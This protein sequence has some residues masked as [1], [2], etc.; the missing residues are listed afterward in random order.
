MIWWKDRAERCNHFVKFSI[1]QVLLKNPFLAMLLFNEVERTRINDA[2]ASI[3][4][5]FAVRYVF[6]DSSENLILGIQLGLL[7]RQFSP[8][9]PH[10]ATR[11][12]L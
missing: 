6:L 8:A 11:G 7:F 1:K 2:Y 10:P 4:K 3:E 5:I 12:Y 9:V